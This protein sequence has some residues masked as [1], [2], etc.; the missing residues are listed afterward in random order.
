M[1]RVSLAL[2]Q[3]FPFHLSLSVVML[4]TVTLLIQHG[5][6]CLSKFNKVGKKERRSRRFGKEEIKLVSLCRTY[7]IYR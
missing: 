6:E 3:Y 2:E 5:R 4:P 7:V 1:I